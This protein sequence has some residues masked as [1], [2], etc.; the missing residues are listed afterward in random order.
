MTFSRVRIRGGRIIGS[1]NKHIAHV[2]SHHM[3]LKGGAI[4]HTGSASS[5]VEQLRREL[6]HLSVHNV[7]K[8]REKKYMAIKFGYRR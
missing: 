6:T 2:N 8:P 3:M 1:H 5:N 7:P 4:H